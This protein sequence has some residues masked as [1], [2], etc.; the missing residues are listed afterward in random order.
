MEAYLNEYANY[1]PMNG[2]NYNT[3]QNLYPSSYYNQG[4]Y[5]NYPTINYSNNINFNNIN[6]INSFPPLETSFNNFEASNNLNISN[7]NYRTS[8]SKVLPSIYIPDNMTYPATNIDYNYNEVNNNNYINN[9]YQASYQNISYINNNDMIS[10]LEYNNN[11][12]HPID[13]FPSNNILEMTATSSNTLINGTTI[14]QPLLLLL[15]IIM[16][17][18]VIIMLILM[19]LIDKIMFY[20]NLLNVLK[21][22]KI[23]I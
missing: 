7:D 1:S 12:P 15:I 17:W 6:N 8:N 13:S 4:E 22:N 2:V 11:I 21:I 19:N 20:L 10:P 16:I 3:A 9:N 18:K 5:D 23:Q 14:K